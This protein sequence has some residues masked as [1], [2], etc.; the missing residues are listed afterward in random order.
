MASG[1]RSV[2][3]TWIIASLPVLDEA[4]DSG[5]VPVTSPV[6]ENE[7][8]EFCGITTEAAPSPLPIGAL[9][10]DCRPIGV[11]DVIEGIVCVGN[12][13][14]ALLPAGEAGDGA[15]I[16]FSAPGIAGAAPLSSSVIAILNVPSTITTTL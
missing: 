14:F 4:G 10:K 3:G 5:T 8:A 2:G 15:S 7:G 13:G 11:G 1:S 9:L 16:E 6:D 12:A